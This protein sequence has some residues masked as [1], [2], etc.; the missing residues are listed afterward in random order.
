MKKDYEGFQKVSSDQKMTVFRHPNGHEV[1]VAHSALSPKLREDLA[2][3]PHMAV[4]G[5]AEPQAEQPQVPPEVLQS[6]IDKENALR[7]PEGAAQVAG[8]E[9]EA[10]KTKAAQ[11]WIASQRA[12][13][14]QN[15]L[16][17]QQGLEDM[18]SARSQAGLTPLSAQAP[19]S[20]PALQL[21][22]TAPAGMAPASVPD[23]PTIPTAAAPGT[24]DPFG[25]I[26][27]SNQYT[28]GLN[29][30]VAGAN[31]QA[32]GL[33]ATAAAKS[34]G[35]ADKQA[36]LQNQLSDYQKSHAQIQG[37]VDALR[38][39]IANGHID[40]DRY[41]KEMHTGPKILT[42]IGLLLS[43]LGSGGAH[44]E[45]AAM[46]FLKQQI[47]HDVEAQKS[48]LGRKEN[49][50]SMN[51]KQ[52]QNLNEATQMTKAMSLEMAASKIEQAALKAQDPIIRGQLMEKVG[53]L[54]RDSAQIV[55]KMAANK[56]IAENQRNIAST[57]APLSLDAQLPLV[58]E[59]KREK[60]AE[61]IADYNSAV[62]ARDDALSGYKS[63]SGVTSVIKHP[64]EN[65]SGEKP[66][67]LNA[68]IAELNKH[69]TGRFNA[70]ENKQL[71]KQFGPSTFD[72]TGPGSNDAARLK[73]LSD[74]SDRAVQAAA[75][76]VRGFGL[77]PNTPQK[78]DQSGNR[79]IKLGPPKI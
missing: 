28:Q 42:A 34:Q 64:L 69:L 63:A 55:G 14:A 12:T 41:L 75:T 53:G 1:K 22:P 45:S 51:M 5:M 10:L 43:G 58:P 44:Q 62:R 15:Q 76:K 37:Q 60:A 46:N 54:K 52:F 27:S 33:Q 57:G 24:N 16:K 48:D 9:A 77:N 13:E 7:R 32:Q 68:S 56:T 2:R 70:D 30:Q 31:L 79:T 61:A 6:A 73:K 66:N 21:A 23:Q 74:F 65:L 20:A 29:Q 59:D 18:N 38:T 49:L 40:P 25:A 36:S 39:D 35:E 26:A 71:F 4:G 11:D 72:T 67:S 19:V 17:A 47:D 3:I 8:A 50:L 78:Y